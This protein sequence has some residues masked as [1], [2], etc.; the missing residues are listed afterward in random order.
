MLR[1]GYRVATIFQIIKAFDNGL[2]DGEW[3]TY[4][5]FPYPHTV[6]GIQLEGEDGVVAG[7]EYQGRV[8]CS[9]CRRILEEIQSIK[10][11]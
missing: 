8:T 11:W 4:V 9:T 2:V 7:P 1:K 10:K 5:M 6:C 3:H